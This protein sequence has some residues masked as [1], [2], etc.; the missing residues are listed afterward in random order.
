VCL[1]HSELRA[2]ST[3]PLG[4]KIVAQERRCVYDTPSSEHTILARA[5]DFYEE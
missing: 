4:C 2:L 5:H 3:L 1:R